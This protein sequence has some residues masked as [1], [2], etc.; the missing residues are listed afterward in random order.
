V[1]GTGSS[2]RNKTSR[3]WV[4]RENQCSKDWGGED[5]KTWRDWERRKGAKLKE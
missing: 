1:S 4:E 3:R 2:H 5:R